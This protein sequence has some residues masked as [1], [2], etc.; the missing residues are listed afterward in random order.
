[1]SLRAAAAS[2]VAL[3]LLGAS[4]S[5]AGKFDPSELP[6]IGG[7]APAFSLEAFRERGEEEAQREVIQLDDQ[8]GPRGGDT[9]MVLLTFV[10]NDSAAAD[11]TQLTKW[12]RRYERDGLVSIAIS[13]DSATAAMGELVA[14]ARRPF[15]VLD[16]KFAIVA[17]RYG[18]PGA[19]FT[20]LLDGEC[21]VLGMADKSASSD[22]E[23]LQA[24]LDERAK[25]VRAAK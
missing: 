10:N 7:I 8:C 20:L 13:T 14:K 3:A 9:T 12:Q 5:F 18:I 4:P 1:M 23:R 19:P 2:V 17:Q 6:T 11:F 22:A 24:A 25:M 21:R 15:R 16:D